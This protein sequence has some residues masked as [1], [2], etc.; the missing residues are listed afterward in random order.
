[1]LIGRLPSSSILLLLRSSASAFTIPSNHN[2]NLPGYI[3]PF[4]T[5]SSSSPFGKLPK[6]SFVPIQ[7]TTT[8]M[9][10]STTTTST[11]NIIPDT[12]DP[13]TWL[14]E[15]ES[16][17]S[18]NFAKNAN[19]KCLSE[20]GD[21]SNTTTYQRVL[22]A[23]ESEDRIPHVRLLGYADDDEGDG[24]DMLLYNFWKDSKNPKGIWRKTTLSSYKSENTQWSTVLDLDE[25]AKKEEVCMF[26]LI[27]I[28]LL[29]F[30]LY[31][32]MIAM[33]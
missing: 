7:T 32:C 21:P 10:A 4:A 13:Y 33:Y 29:C 11:I 26:Y 27:I 8:K 23:L 14:E 25:L 6:K 28:L 9:T 16:T 18:I 12:T 22:A 3:L 19:S 1:M 2:N 31:M 15:V 17:E 5:A 30:D 24:G 20:L